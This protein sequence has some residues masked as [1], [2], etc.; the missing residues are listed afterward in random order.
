MM[1]KAKRAAEWLMAAA[2]DNLEILFLVYLLVVVA[3]IVAAGLVAA[4][5]T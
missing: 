5:G 4:W 2:W 1:R 3:I